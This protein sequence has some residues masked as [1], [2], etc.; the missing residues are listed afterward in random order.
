MYVQYNPCLILSMEL[1]TENEKKRRIE[2]KI[3]PV[4]N[5]RYDFVLPDTTDT[6][7]LT[8]TNELELERI[9]DRYENPDR[10]G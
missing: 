2:I 4:G 6:P 5:K 1:V 8:T 7:T 10:S 3:T 9:S